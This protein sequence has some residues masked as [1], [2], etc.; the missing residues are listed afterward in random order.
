M[1]WRLNLYIPVDNLICATVKIYVSLPVAKDFCLI[2]LFQLFICCWWFSF[3]LANQNAISEVEIHV[4][5]IDM[6]AHTVFAIWFR[7]LERFSLECQPLI[8]FA[9]TSYTIGQKKKLAPLFHPIRV[10]PKP[11]VTHSHTFSRAS[12][13]LHENT[14]SSDWFTWLSGCFVIGWSDYFGVNCTTLDRKLLNTEKT[15]INNFKEKNLVLWYFLR[16][17]T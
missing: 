2:F 1:S 14:L 3:L 17:L 11:I 16:S 6:S 5:T 12:R 7:S 4:L 10:K 15:K 13:Q 8:G 9:S